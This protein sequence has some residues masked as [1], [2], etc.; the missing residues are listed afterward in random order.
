[1]FIRYGN[2]VL[3]IPNSYQAINL[4]VKFNLSEHGKEWREIGDALYNFKDIEVTSS[5]FY[6]LRDLATKHLNSSS[7]S[8]VL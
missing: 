2:K 8:V 5:Q 1:M 6:F 7:F 4:E 3:E